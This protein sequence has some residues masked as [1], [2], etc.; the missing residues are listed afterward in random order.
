MTDLERNKMMNANYCAKILITDCRLHKAP[1]E[2]FEDAS[3]RA[4]GALVATTSCRRFVLSSCTARAPA[5]SDRRYARYAK[6]LPWLL[7]VVVAAWT[8]LRARWQST[9]SMEENGFGT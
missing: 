2:S 8:M 3:I 7:A 6:W 4:L 1:S 5:K 9:T